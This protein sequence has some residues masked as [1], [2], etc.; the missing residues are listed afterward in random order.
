MATIT[1]HR[2]EAFVAYGSN[3]D[4]MMENALDSGESERAEQLKRLITET[5]GDLEPEEETFEMP[6]VL[7][8]APDL[9]EIA[10]IALENC[11][12]NS[13]GFKV[14]DEPENV[15]DGDV[16]IAD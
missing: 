10:R 3:A 7:A 11:L 14:E 4:G 2:F 8:L 1:F 12:D 9:V 5:M 6:Y 15:Y 16:L 13:S